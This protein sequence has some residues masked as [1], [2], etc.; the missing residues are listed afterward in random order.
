MKKLIACLLL[1]ALVLTPAV[2][3]AEESEWDM[4]VPTEITEEIQN[5]FDKATETLMGV[6]YTPVA[7]LGAHENTCCVLCKATVVYPGAKPYNVLMY[8]DT[9][10]PEIRNIYELWIDRHSEKE[11]AITADGTSNCA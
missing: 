4:S 3:S 2:A 6:N 11:P 8:I 10:T 1:I 5:A 7:V 9:E